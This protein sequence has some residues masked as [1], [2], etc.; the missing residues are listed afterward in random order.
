MANLDKKDGGLF[1]YVPQSSVKS[2]EYKIYYHAYHRTW[3]ISSSGGDDENDWFMQ[4]PL[5]DLD[6]AEIAE[7]IEAHACCYEIKMSSEVED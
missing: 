1:E 5:K 6:G 2:L 7:K 4:E 3:M